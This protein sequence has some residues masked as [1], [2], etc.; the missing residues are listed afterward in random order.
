MLRSGHPQLSGST[1]LVLQSR[2]MAAVAVGAER[3]DRAGWIRTGL[4]G[5]RGACRCWGGTA[6]RGERV[7]AAVCPTVR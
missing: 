1:R 6:P 5:E 3:V 4:C 7:V 2:G